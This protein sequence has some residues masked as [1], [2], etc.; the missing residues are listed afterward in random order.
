MSEQGSSTDDSMTDAETSAPAQDG[1]SS[2]PPPEVKAQIRGLLDQAVEL[3]RANRFDEAE[4][5]YRQVLTLDPREANSLTNIGTIFF[6]R[7]QL[8]EGIPFFEA[9]LQA[10]PNQPNALSNLAHGLTKLGRFEEARDACEKAVDLEPV[11]AD[12]WNNLGN[13]RRELGDNEG[14]IT[15]YEQAHALQPTMI[16]ALGNLST[17][18]RGLKLPG[19]A[20]E[21]LK[22]ALAIDPY[23]VDA[24]NE[25][26]NCL[27]E[28]K[29]E[30]EALAAYEEALKVKPDH[31]E[32]LSNI[33]V[34]LTALKRFDDA[35]AYADRA[36]AARHDYPEAWHNRG[37][38]QRGRKRFEEALADFRRALELK[39]DLAD[40]RNNMGIVLHEQGLR[41]E[42]L[43][44]F[45]LAQAI[46]PNLGETHGNRANVLRE[47]NRF[48]EALAEYDTAIAL[49]KDLRD[50][51]NNRAICLAEMGRIDEAIAEFDEAQRIDPSFAEAPW[52]RSI[53][54]IM[55]G[56]DAEGWPDYELRWKRQE[57]ENTPDPYGKAPWLGE[58]DIA[59]KVLMITAEQGIGDT[60]QMLRYIPLLAD[61][62]I[63]VVAAVQNALVE[64]T[65]G[66]PGVWSVLGERQ[67]IPHWDEY[68]P[69]MS[70]PLAFGGDQA[71]YP[72][73]V[74]YI[75]VPAE[76]KARWAERLGP[77]TK[78]RIG[79][80]WS[81]SRDHKN[82]RN[83]SVALSTI[84]PLLDLDAEFISLQIDYRE[85]DLPLDARILDLKDEI[86]SFV[87][88]AAIVEQVDLVISVD[89]SVAHV[90]GALGT[91]LWLLLPYMADF[92]WYREGDETLWYPS[93]RLWRQGDDRVWPPVIERVKAAAEAWLKEGK[94]P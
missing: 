5:V 91:P 87:D 3:H 36:I 28:M 19:A 34:A 66:V 29:Q 18:L 2:E 40:A 82:D 30:E 92:R 53:L 93:A 83:R 9:S 63:K 80:A 35:V 23:Y 42:A 51:H 81:G 88:T 74:P 76:A 22:R 77:R 44:Q 71:S 31:P 27:Q 72:R 8:A 61:K 85:A 86:K 13:A 50:A 37:N 64:L 38:A 57:F 56:R 10:K 6:Q 49:K 41:D 55:A 79:L 48:D 84:A 32:A 90:T 70:L 11:N 73:N 24:W 45:D 89:T 7:G 58:R 12:A 39:P 60:L 20:A 54:L 46:N 67:P 59:G 94:G 69:T 43:A 65:Q 21:T 15:A 68:I 26:G 16:T 25:L 17:L 75:S 33:S 1:R 62:G 47:L 52:N 78:P 4:A 14:A